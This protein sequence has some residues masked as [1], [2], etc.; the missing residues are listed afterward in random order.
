MRKLAL[1]A[2]VVV[3]V[4]VLAASTWAQAGKGGCPM[5]G[6]MKPMHH[7]RSRGMGDKP[8]ILGRAEELGLTE[9]QAEKVRKMADD[10][11]RKRIDLS[12]AQEKA[13]LYL[14]E[15][16]RADELDMKDVEKRLDAAFQA[17]KE[18]KL[19]RIRHMTEVRKVLTEEQREKLGDGCPMMSD[20]CGREKKGAG[21]AR[22]GQGMRCGMGMKR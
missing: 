10:W 20:S 7:G 5:G 14:R 12:A 1:L 3:L 11:I 21:C 2:G 13:C 17:Q 22:Q 15:A 18:M 9:D 6:G 16:L 19:G 8:C 4:G